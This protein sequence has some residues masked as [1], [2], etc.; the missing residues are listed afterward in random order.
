MSTLD[1]FSYSKA[2]VK[3]VKSV[4]FSVWDPEEIVSFCCSLCGP[5]MRSC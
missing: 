1:R 2:P 4:Q 3:R 5:C